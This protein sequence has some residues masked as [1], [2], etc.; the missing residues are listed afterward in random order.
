MDLAQ[1]ANFILTTVCMF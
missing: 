1:R